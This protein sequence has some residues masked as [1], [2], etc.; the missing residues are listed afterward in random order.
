MLSNKYFGYLCTEKIIQDMKPAI[1]YSS[2]Y[3][4]HTPC[5]IICKV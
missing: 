3:G 1:I 2:K 5:D 4:T